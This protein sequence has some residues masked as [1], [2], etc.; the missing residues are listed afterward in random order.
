MSAIPGGELAANLQRLA[1]EVNNIKIAQTQQNA[2][3]VQQGVDLNSLR[4]NIP[5]VGK[6]AVDHVNQT[7]AV[8]IAELQ[9]EVGTF[10]STSQVIIDESLQQLANA[11]L[12]HK[13]QQQQQ[14]H[15]QQHQHIQH[16]QQQQHQ[17]Q[18]QQP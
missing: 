17:P 14:Q 6:Q 1:E 16:Q 8:K 3:L 9:L 11:V 2:E 13:Q 12:Q 5:E 10:L 4:L 15:Q 7:T 18:Q